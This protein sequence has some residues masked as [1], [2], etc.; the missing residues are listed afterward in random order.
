MIIVVMTQNTKLISEHV[1]HININLDTI[2]L[3]HR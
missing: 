3:Y 2:R 1:F